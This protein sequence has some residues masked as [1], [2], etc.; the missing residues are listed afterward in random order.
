MLVTVLMV[1]CVCSFLLAPLV[2]RA[3]RGNQEVPAPA[4]EC[5]VAPLEVA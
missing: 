2:G 4:L 3:M 1:W 5:T